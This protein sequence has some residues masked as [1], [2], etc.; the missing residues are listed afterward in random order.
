[1]NEEEITLQQSME[2]DLP[3][4][5]SI[6][7][8]EEA[9]P[10]GEEHAQADPCGTA[11]ALDPWEEGGE[12]ELEGIDPEPEEDLKD[13]SVSADSL[14]DP[15]YDPGA[16][17]EADATAGLDELRNE[18]R[19]LQ[20]QL[21]TA[22]SLN[23]RIGEDLREFCRLYPDVVVGELPDSVWADARRGV[24]LAAAYA[25]MERR[26]LLAQQQA[27]KANA[28]NQLRSTGA[29]KGVEADYYSPDEVRTMTPRQVRENYE[30]I[31]K[32]MQKWK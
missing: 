18:L 1:M 4:R 32:S 19:E 20:A 30:K 12:D 27:A 21:D 16:A 5:E 25:L 17:S 3:S 10:E 29:L 14:P 2:E 23:L 13:T 28:Q 26:Q 15:D 9:N 8:P 31:M 6:A 11:E 7:A 24:P 22:H